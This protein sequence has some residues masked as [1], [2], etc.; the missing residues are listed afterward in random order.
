MPLSYGKTVMKKLQFTTK[1]HSFS[2]T[3]NFA[4][5]NKSLDVTEK[6]IFSRIL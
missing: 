3:N 4:L 5:W 2:K 6:K 1:V